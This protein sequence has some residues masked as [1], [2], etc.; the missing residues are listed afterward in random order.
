[1]AQKAFLLLTGVYINSGNN[2]P[3]RLE[4]PEK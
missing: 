2:A 4:I 1:M 3:K